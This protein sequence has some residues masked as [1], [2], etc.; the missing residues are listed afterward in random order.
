MKNDIIDFLDL[1]NANNLTDGKLFWGAFFLVQGRAVANKIEKQ[2]SVTLAIVE[3]EYIALSMASKMAIWMRR[4]ITNHEC[5]VVT[6]VD[7]IEEPLSIL[8]WDNKACI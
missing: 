1:N 4:M 6:N 2:K 8:F 3:V 7:G 5:F